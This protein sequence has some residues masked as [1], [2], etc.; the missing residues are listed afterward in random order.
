MPDLEFYLD[1]VIACILKGQSKFLSCLSV[2]H[3][4]GDYRSR[5][6]DWTKGLGTVQLRNL[7]VTGEQDPD[8]L[9]FAYFLAILEELFHAAAVLVPQQ[10]L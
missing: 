7:N 1:L 2:L 9:L 5:A 4:Y 10:L 6:F 8:G 3:L